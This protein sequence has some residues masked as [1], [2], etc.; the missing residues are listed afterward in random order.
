MDYKTELRKDREKICDKYIKLFCKKH[1]LYFDHWIGDEVG[2]VADFGVYSFSF[3]SIVKDIDEDIEAGLI[4]Q[5]YDNSV[6]NQDTS[7][8]L[9]SYALRQKKEAPN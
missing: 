8:N 1:D 6:E 5:W 2:G 9:K 4:L 7:I 3:T